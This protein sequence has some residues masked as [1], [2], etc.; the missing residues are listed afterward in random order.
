MVKGKFLDTVNELTQWSLNILNKY[1]NR[2]GLDSIPNKT[3]L[4]S[5]NKFKNSRCSSPLVEG[6]LLQPVD[7][8]STSTFSWIGSYRGHVKL[9][10]NWGVIGLHLCICISDNPYRREMY[11]D[12]RTTI[13][14]KRIKLAGLELISWLER[15]SLSKSHQSEEECVFLILIHFG[16]WPID[17][18][19]A[20]QALSHLSCCF[21]P[22]RQ[23]NARWPFNYLLLYTVLYVFNTVLL[24]L[25]SKEYPTKYS[26]N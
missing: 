18:L 12:S 7:R 22:G 15:A 5:F 17:L 8:G 21:P 13:L 26:L 6:S 16:I 20:Q 23:W 9:K 3:K 25:G 19:R 10:R 1:G 14:H 24:L 11:S 4:F 2:T